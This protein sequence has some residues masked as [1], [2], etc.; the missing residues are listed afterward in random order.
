MKKN[1]KSHVFFLSL[2]FFILTF[3]SCS[4]IKKETWNVDSIY[5]A[6]YLQFCIDAD[7]YLNETGFQ[8]AVLVG[9]GDKI[10]FANGFG[11]CD[12]KP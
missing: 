11:F 4:S 6:K 9:H 3:I 5:N 10:A 2:S 8:G 12:D 1:A 7:N